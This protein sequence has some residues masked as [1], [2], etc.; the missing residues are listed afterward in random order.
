ML[1]RLNSG[2]SRYF[3]NSTS[4][5]AVFIG[6]S[7]PCGR[8]SVME[9]PDRVKRV[10]PPTTTIPKTMPPHPRIHHASPL[11]GTAAAVAVA[12]TAAAAAVVAGRAGARRSTER[13]A[14]CAR[15][16]AKNLPRM[17]FGPELIEGCIDILVQ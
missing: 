13:R 11:Y 3:S 9:S 12:V 17:N 1:R 5:S 10:V 14:S 8:Q 2:K 6:G 7:L 16:A 4:H 15:R